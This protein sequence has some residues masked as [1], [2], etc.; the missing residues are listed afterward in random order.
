MRL[1]Q[2]DLTKPPG[3]LGR[4]EE[5]AEWL[6]TWQGRASPRCRPA[7]HRVFA[8]NHGVAARGVSA[9]PAEVNAQMVQNFIAGGAAI[10]QLAGAIDGDLR[11]Y[12]MDLDQPIAD[13]TQGP[14]MDEARTRRAMAYGM[15]AAEPGIDVL[16]LGE[17]GIG[18]TTAAAALCL[19][20]F[21]G[22]RADWVGPGTGVAATRWR[23]R[24]RPCRRASRTTRA[25]RAIRLRVLRR[26]RRRGAGGDRRRHPGGAHG[27]HPRAARRLR[28][29]GAAAVLHAL[30]PPRAGPLP[31]GA[32][33]GRARPHACSVRAAGPEAAARSRHAAGRSLG[34]RAG[35]AAPEGGLRLP[36]R[37]GDLRRGRRELEE[38]LDARFSRPCSPLLAASP[39]SPIRRASPTAAE[40]QSIIEEIKAFREKVAKA[41]TSKD[42]PTLRAI[43]ADAFTHTHGSGKLDNKDARLVS[44]MAGEPLIENAPA[45]ELSYRVFAGPTVIVT[46]KSPILNVKEQKTY[47]FRWVCVYVTGKDGWLLAVSQ[48]TRLPAS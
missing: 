12:E 34:C 26:A 35:G 38:C 27:P 36:R 25:M 11:V 44:A 31:G 19:A 24:S 47:D 3:S 16:C 9:Y 42:F 23:A 45:T 30:D 43:Y 17:M 28:L 20:L 2:A 6:A 40:A 21:G 15:M 32:S 14:A 8:G 33:L 41:V 29:H 5:I 4:L 39:P 18:N 46:G 48:A 10:N 22:T 7:A 13:F 1:R 37:H